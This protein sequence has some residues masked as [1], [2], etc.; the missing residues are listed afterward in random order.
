M[1]YIDPNLIDQCK[2]ANWD[3]K[4]QDWALRVQN[5]EDKSAEIE[6][7]GS[8]WGKFKPNFVNMFGDKCWY[9]ESPR[10]NTD[11]DVDHFRPKG[12]VKIAEKT[13][14]TRLVNGTEE[15]HSGYWWLAFEAKNYRYS[16]KFS[17]QP[18]DKGGKHDYFP[19][20]DERSRVWQ[21]CTLAAHVNEDVQLLDP[22]SARDV[23]LLSYDKSPGQVQARF[24]EHIDP[25]SFSRVEES[26]KRYNMNHTSIL[27]ARLEVINS[28]K[29]A[30]RL[31]ENVWC[32]SNDVQAQ[33]A[34]SVRDNE[35]ILVS[36]C[37]RKSKFSAA[38]VAF[39]KPYKIE[40][41]LAN[42]LPRLDLTD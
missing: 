39:V 42:V 14:A 36:A 40:P 13:Y 6:A 3:T 18:R 30:L 26:K 31:L 17:N 38:A 25:N 12:A 10:Y 7:I 41:W 20:M 34:D 16:S 19:L 27:G 29:V 11:N 1:R 2:P 15:K 8:P 5:A 35:D 24:D 4:A 21:P 23:T 28:V 32:L 37:D 9:S 33:L 22:C